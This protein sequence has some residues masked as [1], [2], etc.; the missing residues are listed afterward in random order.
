[1]PIFETASLHLFNYST[2]VENHIKIK[3]KE[4]HN[5]DN[6][7]PPLRTIL[8]CVTITIPTRHSHKMIQTHP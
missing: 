5:E 8:F 6:L 2:A 1:M 3:I 4:I 7:V